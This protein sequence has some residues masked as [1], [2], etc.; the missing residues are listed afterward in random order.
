M[1][2]TSLTDMSGCDF[3]IRVP[4]R[5]HPEAGR[6]GERLLEWSSQVGLT[7]DARERARLDAAGLHLLAARILPDALR[8]D[9]ELFAQW[10]AW[11]TYL[12]DEQD[13]GAMGRSTATIEATFSPVLRILDDRPVLEGSGPAAQA[14]ADLWPRTAVGMSAAWQRRIRHHIDRYRDAFLVQSAH[15]RHGTVPSPEDYPALRRY[16]SGMF[17]YDLIEVAHGTEVPHHITDAHAWPELCAASSDIIAWCNDLASLRRETA[18]GE[19]TNYVTVLQRATGCSQTAAI[20]QVADHIRA[21]SAG[22]AAARSHLLAHVRD[23]SPGLLA[24]ISTVADTIS[25]MPG[26]HLAWLPESGRFS[27]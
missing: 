12:D 14:L 13:E 4:D 27:S 21:R 24:D 26:A 16:D 11:L 1:T 18:Q 17:I 15:H 3:G 5:I 20:S 7:V 9:V 6:I 22:L 8:A 2:H 25:V 19:T 10:I 23:T